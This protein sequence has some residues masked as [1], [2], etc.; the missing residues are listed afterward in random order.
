MDPNLQTNLGGNPNASKEGFDPAVVLAGLV[1]AMVVLI[2]FFGA[3]NYFNIISISRIFP[4]QLGWLPHKAFVVST[5]VVQVNITPTPTKTIPSLPIDPESK[6][7]YLAEIYYVFP[8]VEIRRIAPASNGS[9]LEVFIPN[10]EEIFLPNF[11]VTSETVIVKGGPTA[12][13]ATLTDLNEKDRLSINAS[14]DLKNKTWKLRHINKVF[15]TTSAS[16]AANVAPN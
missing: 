1:G 13:P 6:D 16:E 2:V 8:N 12:E 11:V 14:Y 15:R 3:L 9:Q 10:N 4:N 7:V 5:E